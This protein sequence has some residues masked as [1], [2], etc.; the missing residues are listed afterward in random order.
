L[1][2][3][4]AVAFFAGLPYLLKQHDIL[5]TKLAAGRVEL[6][7]PCGEDED[8]DRESGDDR[9]TMLNRYYKSRSGEPC[10]LTS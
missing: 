8:D 10:A 5:Q 3:D 4:E 6:I 9:K 1:S 7:R 2:Y